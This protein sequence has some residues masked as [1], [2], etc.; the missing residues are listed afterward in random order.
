ML[1]VLTIVATIVALAGLSPAAASAATVP[2]CSAANITVESLGGPNFYIDSGSSPEFR[3]SYTGYKIANNTGAA[4]SDIWVQLSDFTGGSLALASGQAAAQRAGDVDA[5]AATARF[6]YL[7]ASATNANAQTHTVTVY[8]H[9]PALPGAVALCSTVGGFSSVQSTLAASANKVTGITV[10]G[11]APKLGSV[12]TVTVTGNTGTVGAGI[13][14]DKESLWMSPA[15]AE[16]WPA[17]VFRLLSTSLTISPNGTTPQQTYTDILRV[18]GLGSTARDYTATYTFQA[19]G[20]S[21]TA[22]T[23]KPVQEI[24]SGT[25]VKHTGSYSVSLPAIQP[26]VS[27]LTVALTAT[28]TTLPYGGGTASLEGTITG[29]SGGELDGLTMTLPAGAS[30]VP[31]TAKWGGVAIPDP[32]LSGSQLAFTGPFVVGDNTL[33]IDILFGAATGDQT[34]KFLGNIGTT[35][36]GTTATPTDGTNPASATVTVDAPPTALDRSVTIPLN[37]PVTINIANLVDD[38]DGDSWTVTSG[39]AS[40]GTVSVDGQFVIYTPTLDWEGVDSFTY[41]VDDGRGGTATA[42]IT[43]TVDPLAPQPQAITFAQAEPVDPNT[44]FTVAPTAS[45]EL[46]VILT[47]ETPEICSTDGYTVTALASGTCVLTATQ[48]GN[49]IFSAADPVTREITINALPQT[50]TFAQPEPVDPNTSFT[51]APT[52]SSE[53]PVTLTSETPLICTT[54]GYT[55]TAVAAGTCVLTATQPGNG[56]Y[57][58]ATPVT[59]EVTIN[60]LAQTVTFAQPEPVDPNTSFTVAPTA[61]SELPVTLTSETPLICTTDGYTVTALAAGTC[62]LTASQ[63]G[64]G[65]Y[66]PATPVTREITINNTGPAPQ[67]ITFDPTPVVLGLTPGYQLDATASSGLTVTYEVISGDCTLDGDILIPSAAGSCTVK[68][69]QVGNDSYEAAEPVTGVIEFV[70]PEDDETL[71]EVGTAVTVNVL[72]NDPTGVEL[73][74]LTQPANGTAVLIEGQIQY[75]PNPGFRGIDTFTYTVTLNGRSVE[76]TVQ[77][78]VG[79]QAPLVSGAS[80]RQVAGTT[81]TLELHPVDPNDD[82]MTV[83]ATTT[84]PRITVRMVGNTLSITALPGASGNARVTVRVTDQPGASATATVTTRISPPAVTNVGR[85]LTKRGTTVRW[86]PAPTAGAVY[87]TRIDGKVVCRSRRPVC[88]T[89]RIIGPLMKVSVRTLGRDGTTSV[90]ADAPIVGHG[91]I[92]IV[93]VY[94]NTDSS[95]L[96][97]RSRRTLDNAIRSIKRDGFANVAVDGYTDGDGNWLYNNILSRLRT[98]NVADYLNANGGITGN[99]GWHGERAPAATNDS[100]SGKAKNRRVEVLI[101]F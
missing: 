60:A 20:F 89:R 32:T 25:Q 77:V 28:P 68:T 87:E 23:L 10:S 50:I 40:H 13:T 51:V 90:L 97:K 16:S 42:T 52:A 82:P 95:D 14:G 96:T 49:G 38:P 92:L 35:L 27:D 33:T 9:N 46:L 34:V 59:R 75:V 101:T 72:G 79:N 45:S 3:S 85:T 4:L 56:T 47:S 26:P 43:I 99:E 93:T 21:A 22:T 94:F 70:V 54:D 74:S 63:P 41:T 83:E 64:N 66:G 69:T 37:V 29:T 53:L 81:K 30:F 78:T 98:R 12:F 48:P 61:S 39:A 55:V 88:T 100:R 84:D 76:R 58:P 19:V 8:Q 91:R 65:I 24:S 18:A 71:T 15:V 17:G 73:T 80:V 36:I 11:S 44:S 5:A 67:T 57:G 1:R 62:V 2:T 7:T 86:A 31:G 6:W